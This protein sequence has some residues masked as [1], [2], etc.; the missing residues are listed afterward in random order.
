MPSVGVYPLNRNPL[1]LI[2]GNLIPRTIIELCCPWAFM[3][4]HGL[5]IFET[6][7]GP[8]IGGDSRGAKG[9]AANPRAHA[10]T[11]GAAL[12]HAPGVDS[13]HRFVRQRA[14]AAGGGAEEGSLAAVADAG[15]LNIRVDI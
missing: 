8:K 15:R 4:G 5:G 12:D 13:V 2:K 1:D 10:E 6:A 14:G 3:R 7:A 9:V 11:T